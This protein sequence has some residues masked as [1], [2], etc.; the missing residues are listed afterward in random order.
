MNPN[1]DDYELRDE[2]DLTQLRVMPKGRF[3]QRQPKHTAALTLKH[4]LV[5]QII[6]LMREQHFSKAALAQQLNTSLIR[7][8]K[9][10]D[11]MNDTV[12]LGMLEQIALILGKKLRVELV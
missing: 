2:Y 1:F 12:T 9:L 4:D 6:Q 5:L 8:D 10:L 11:P 7:L 3:A